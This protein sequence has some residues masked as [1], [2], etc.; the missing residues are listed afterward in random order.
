MAHGW[1]KAKGSLEM[2]YDCQFPYSKQ[3]SQTTHEAELVSVLPSASSRP[4][5]KTRPLSFLMTAAALL[6]L[7]CASCADSD[8]LAN[9]L[10]I[11]DSAGI[12][13]AEYAWPS[14]AMSAIWAS[15]E[16]EPTV[17]IGL[18]EG[19]APYL[20]W[21]V[22]S[23]FEA[24]SGEILVV[25]QGTREI[26]VFDGRGTHVRT[27]AGSGQGPGEFG[28]NPTVRLVPPDTVLGW[29]SRQRRLT[30]FTLDGKLAKERALAGTEAG[31]AP[32]R[33][34]NASRWELHPQGTLVGLASAPSGPRT[35]LVQDQLMLLIVRGASGRI[36][37]I[38]DLPSYPRLWVGRSS[39]EAVLYPTAGP[40][41][42]GIRVA[43]PSIVVADDPQGRWALSIYDLDGTLMGSIRAAIPRRET[44]DLAR[45]A[46]TWLLAQDHDLPPADRGDYELAVQ[47]MPVPDS[48]PAIS[49]LFVDA[50]DRVWVQRWRGWWEQEEGSDIYDV[51][52][53]SGQWLGWVE[54]S[55]SFGRILSIGEDHILFRQTG[56]LDAPRVRKHR[57][58]QRTSGS[59][60]PDRS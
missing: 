18:A 56:A 8:R 21:R 54:V 30:W 19:L 29:D 58:L 14:A 28:G 13:I 40:H 31:D 55:R 5:V 52:D 3:P 51:I 57:L 25:D 42:W 6:A 53:P 17:E 45:A 10:V 12:R 9:T 37:W 24:T 46:R 22:E 39:T 26:R 60:D 2:F 38:R 20:F 32:P 23:A 1:G 48:A 34:M 16:P 7:S 11:R 41:N 15:V 50:N 35:A 27:F 33:A 36:R 43:P 4:I 44:A 59:A 49:W 47:R